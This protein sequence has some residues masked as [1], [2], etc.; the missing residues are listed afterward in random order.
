MINLVKLF[1]KTINL[2]IG[3]ELIPYPEYY[4]DD[5]P[6]RRV[7]S[8]EKARKD[9]NFN[10]KISLKAGLTKTWTWALKN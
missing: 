7:A 5:E 9:L 4:P 6:V 3:Y 8:I 2:E 10:P 1:G